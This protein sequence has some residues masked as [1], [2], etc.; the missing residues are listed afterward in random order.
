[1]VVMITLNY[2]NFPLNGKGPTMSTASS[3]YTQ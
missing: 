1:M 2:E 3:D